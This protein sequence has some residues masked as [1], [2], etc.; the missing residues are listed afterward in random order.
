[1]ASG[2]GCTIKLQRKY[3]IRLVN[4]FGIFRCLLNYYGHDST[5]LF[6]VLAVLCNFS[7]FLAIANV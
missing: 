6:I 3:K 5:G 4:K 1:M 2:V 7:R